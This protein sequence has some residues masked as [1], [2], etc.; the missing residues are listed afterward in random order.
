MLEVQ[1]DL[2]EELG[3]I[4]M[5]LKA[6]VSVERKRKKRSE[7]CRGREGDFEALRCSLDALSLRATKGS[8]GGVEWRL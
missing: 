8:E 7:L 4:W 2:G 1:V 5:E 3:E 6:L